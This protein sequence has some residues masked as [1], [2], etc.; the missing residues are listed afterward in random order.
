MLLRAGSLIGLRCMWNCIISTPPLQL[1]R[2]QIRA[3]VVL[4]K[5]PGPNLERQIVVPGM[6]AAAWLPVQRAD[7]SMFAIFPGVAGPTDVLI[8][9]TSHQFRR[10]RPLPPSWRSFPHQHSLGL[11]VV[12]TVSDV[13]LC[14]TCLVSSSVCLFSACVRQFGLR[15]ACYMYIVIFFLPFCFFIK[16]Y[17]SLGPRWC[18]SGKGGGGVLLYL[19]FSFF[20]ARPF[21]DI[22]A[23]IPPA[24][25]LVLKEFTRELAEFPSHTRRYVLN[26]I[27]FGFRVGWEPQRVSLRSRASNMR[28]C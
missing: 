9:P 3:Q 23:P 5:V 16:D 6:R 2:C 27:Q 7:T 21:R 15:Y 17:S 13:L 25:P 11:E 24:T 18:V 12:D 28:R 20:I 1:G 8:A 10:L 14:R 22:L 4:A 26:G 19:F